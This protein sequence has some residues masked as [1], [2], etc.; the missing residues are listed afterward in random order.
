MTNEETARL[1]NLIIS[2]WPTG[3]KGYVWTDVLGPLDRALA[4]RSYVLMRNRDTRIT[5]ADFLDQ[6]RA[7]ERRQREAEAPPPNQLPLSS[8]PLI[9]RNEHIAALIKRSEAGDQI[10]ATEL[11]NWQRVLRRPAWLHIS[12]HPA[13]NHERNE[14]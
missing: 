6:Y 13:G 11:N 10:A 7:L 8:T 9:S 2:T 4:N 5:V 1:V 3:P 14:P 12:N